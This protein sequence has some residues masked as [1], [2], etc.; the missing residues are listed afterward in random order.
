MI[1]TSTRSHV[2]VCGP[3]YNHGQDGVQN[4]TQA[5]LMPMNHDATGDHMDADV[6][7]ANQG[8]C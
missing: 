7:N 1:H 2:A 3:C 6:P 4:S 8:L 5:V